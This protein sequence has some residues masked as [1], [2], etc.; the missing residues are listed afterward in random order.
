MRFENLEKNLYEENNKIGVVAIVPFDGEEYRLS[1]DNLQKLK[2]GIINK[3]LEK[4]EM[5]PYTANLT[6][7]IW[8]YEDNPFSLPRY[9]LIEV[10][11]K[12]NRNINYSIIF[13]IPREILTKYKINIGKMIEKMPYESLYKYYEKTKKEVE[14]YLKE[15]QHLDQNFFKSFEL[16]KRLKLSP[17]DL[18]EISY[19]KEYKPSGIYLDKNYTKIEVDNETKA[20]EIAERIINTSEN[21]GKILENGYFVRIET[22]N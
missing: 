8:G 5:E 7:D 6:M 12:E 11:R 18:K 15:N 22:L 16:I 4:R 20:I 19:E 14:E 1:S 10:N 17:I 13:V 3:V 9:I 21:I 2:I